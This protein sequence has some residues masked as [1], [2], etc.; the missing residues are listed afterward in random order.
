MFSS[1][2][3]A[4]RHGETSW[5]A[6]GFFQGHS[7]IPLAETGVRQVE[8]NGRRFKAHL[9]TVGISPSAIAIISSP[10]SRAIQ[11]SRIMCAEL[12]I[13]ESRLATDPRLKEASFGRWEGLTTFEV[14][15]RFR[16][17]RRLRKE[18][19]WNFAPSGGQSY[20]DI[21]SAMGDFL[22]QFQQRCAAVL[23]P[24]LRENNEIEHFRDPGENGNAP[25]GMSS[26][27]PVLIV[28]HTGNIRVA[29]AMLQGLE[30]EMAMAARVPQDRLLYW[31][32]KVAGWI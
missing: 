22:Q 23:C 12:G 16:E 4:M 26:N 13:P 5:N 17:E 6:K 28:T 1:P 14:K 21:S 9:E 8:E 7:D 20:A 32:G 27:H 15:E 25:D 3:Y 30:R 11:S 29:L 18:D 24:E 2:F 31:D 19:R 10:L